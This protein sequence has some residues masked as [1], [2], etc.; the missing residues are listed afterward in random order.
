MGAV[1]AEGQGEEVGVWGR[2]LGLAL[3]SPL[4]APLQGEMPGGVPRPQLLGSPL[5]LQPFYFALLLS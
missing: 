2:L 4:P 3:P 5:F 1:A